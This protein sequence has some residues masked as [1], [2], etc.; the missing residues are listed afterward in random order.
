MEAI[1]SKKILFLTILIFSA[2]FLQSCA[3]LFTGDGPDIQS[4]DPNS[5]YTSS[6][7]SSPQP[8]DYNS[9]D[10]HD[11]QVVHAVQNRDIVLGMN[12]AEVISSW[13]RPRDVEEAGNGGQGN[14][15]WLYY[16]GNSLRYGISP[17]KIIYFENGK[18]VGWESPR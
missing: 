9:Q 3:S 6:S 8:L 4:G 13:G 5:D 2:A 14:E 1:M 7:Q 18:V 16:S 15:R 12:S 11:T 17:A 10:Y